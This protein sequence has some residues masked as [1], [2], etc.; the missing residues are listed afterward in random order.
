MK[1]KWFAAA[2]IIFALMTSALEA[3]DNPVPDLQKDGRESPPILSHNCDFAAV[4]TKNDILIPGIQQGALPFDDP[5]D[6][7]HEFIISRS[8]GQTNDDGYGI[9][10]MRDWQDAILADQK[11]YCPDIYE[12][13]PV[14]L[15]SAHAAIMDPASQAVLVLSH[16]RNGTGGWAGGNHPFTLEWEGRTYSFMHN[17]SIADNVKHAMH[18]DLYNNTGAFAG[19]WFLEHPSNWVSPE[20]ADDYTAFIDSE[21]LFHWIMKNVIEGDGSVL[22]GMHAAL[23]G[24]L[25]T[26]P[27]PQGGGFVDLRVAFHDNFDSNKIN[28]VLAD[29]SALHVFRN[30]NDGSHLLSYRVHAD[31]GFVSVKTQDEAG[32]TPVGQFNAAYIPRNADPVQINLFD[33]YGMPVYVDADNVHGPWEG[34]ADN[35]YRYIQDG[36]QNSVDGNVVLV[37]EGTYQEDVSFVRSDFTGRFPAA[38][39][40]RSD[41]DG[42]PSTYDID[43]F[44]TLI[45]GTGTG[46]TATFDCGQGAYSVLD[47]FMVMGGSSDYGGGV[48]CSPFSSPTIINNQIIG[49]RA[50]TGYGYGGG[51]FCDDDSSPLI[52]NNKIS[53]NHAD[54]K[55][56]GICCWNGSRAVIRNNLIVWNSANVWGGGIYLSYCF[57]SITNNTIYDNTA[58][59]GDGG[60]IRCWHS[61]PAITNTILWQNTGGEIA[62]S[63]GDPQVS[64]CDIE[65]GWTG[66]GTGNIDV[67]P[68]FFD[69]MFDDFHLRQD[70][71]QPGVDNPCVDGGDPASTMIE[72]T[73]RSDQI[74][75]SGIVDM[76]YH[77]RE[78][79]N[80]PDFHLGVFPDPLVAGQTGTFVVTWGDPLT[81]TY[82]VYSLAGTGNTYIPQLDVTLGLANPQRAAGPSRTDD[83]GAYVW[84][85]PIPQNA[86]GFD[87]W[88]QAI[89]FGQA[90]D[91]VVATIQ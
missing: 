45:V 66:A 59:P 84:N 49:N 46:S 12:T 72:G 88:F 74:Q 64:Y 14:P 34:T 32:R 28:F 39:T 40:V 85:L 83:T 23:T 5:D 79:V 24:E 31:E 6:F 30:T 77:Y 78:A 20:D 42:D 37:L 56:G 86:A 89:Q 55:G 16:A 27:P 48:F 67:Y 22:G 71:C 50:E 11:Y 69:P 58:S 38:V 17:G 10:F 19:A 35:P 60:G 57:P 70:P 73:T 68:N 51:I 9:L 63:V 4:I 25:D 44:T 21:I 47:G 65:G 54:E 26:P 43:S 81:D 53:A 80:Q 1:T 91:V 3:V 90:T 76:G 41:G 52:A 62:V 82:L 7:F 36:I 33:D 8:T 18:Y 2:L 87:V 29:R 75:D 15:D 61:S 13:N